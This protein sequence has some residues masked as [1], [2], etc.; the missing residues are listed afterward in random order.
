[1]RLK[2]KLV[3]WIVLG[4]A[5]LVL[6]F[7]IG[8]DGGGGGGSYFLGYTI[9]GK[10]ISA[11]DNA[12][13][14]N[15]EV[16]LSDASGTDT[17]LYSTITDS[18]GNYLFGGLNDG[19]YKVAVVSIPGGYSFNPI[20]KF[21][22]ISDANVSGINFVGHLPYESQTQTIG[23]TGGALSLQN[24]ASVTFDPNFLS[25]TSQITFSSYPSDL[26]NTQGETSLS[27]IYKINIPTENISSY[28]VQNNKQF[29]NKIQKQ[30]QEQE[31]YLKLILPETAIQNS[32]QEC[33]I[34][35]SVIICGTNGLRGQS[36]ISPQGDAEL[37]IP[38]SAIDP[39]RMSGESTGSTEIA[40]RI[41]G[42]ITG[43]IVKNASHIQSA[44]FSFENNMKINSYWDEKGNA[45][46]YTGNKKIIILIHGW[47]GLTAASY[48]LSEDE[49]NVYEGMGLIKVQDILKPQYFGWENFAKFFYHDTQLSETF[50]LFTYRYDTDEDVNISAENLYRAINA[51]FTNKEI[52]LIGHSMGGLVGHTLLCNHPDLY[53]YS[54]SGNKIKKLITL[55]TPFHGSPIVQTEI[56]Q[57]VS[58]VAEFMGWVGLSSDGFKELAWDGF[59]RNSSI[60]SPD[61]SPWVNKISREPVPIYSMYFPIAGKFTSNIFNSH[62][63]YD[64]INN[65]LNAYGYTNDGIVP[66]CSSLFRDYDPASSSYVSKPYIN[67]S[68]PFEDYDHSQIQTGKNS[69]DTT[70]FEKIKGIL[71]PTQSGFQVKIIDHSNSPVSGA[72]VILHNQDGTIKEYKTTGNDGTADFG[73]INQDRVTLTV[74]WIEHSDGTATNYDIQSFIDIP[75][76]KNQTNTIQVYTFNKIASINV[77]TAGSGFDYVTYGFLNCHS[78][79]LLITGSGYSIC[80]YSSPAGQ[81]AT[82]DVHSNEIQPDGKI[83]IAAVGFSP[84]G[85]FVKYGYL[86]DQTLVDSGTYTV[87]LDKT[88]VDIN[89]SS[90]KPLNWVS[91]GFGRKSVYNRISYYYLT[92][93]VNGSFKVANQF[94]PDIDYIFSEAGVWGTNYDTVLY[95]W[96]KYSS[97]PSSLSINMPD[98]SVDN[99]TFDGRYVNWVIGG[100]AQ[101]DAIEI[102]LRFTDGNSWTDWTIWVNP[103]STSWD[104]TK[105]QL[106]SGIQ[107]WLFNYHLAESIDVDVVNYDTINGFDDLARTYLANPD[108]YSLAN[109]MYMASRDLNFGV[110]NFGVSEI[111][112]ASKELSEKVFRKKPE[113]KKFLFRK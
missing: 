105:L 64:R 96:K 9:S 76:L 10:V 103:S 7:G 50:D 29:S 90:N 94:P 34:I 111:N 40:I 3:N 42:E 44:L 15:M 43:E 75:Y 104:I 100:T 37:I 68:V 60:P 46:P 49:Y 84:F 41:T 63:L 54:S 98:I 20:Q 52:V 80:G 13:L 71:L 33:R 51:V 24:G 17:T 53:N 81:T 2:N 18:S 26:M 65:I 35:D 74:A 87:N 11:S 78:T 1:M 32:T 73:T 107:G 108:L 56:A 72:Y 69:D 79:L 97:I 67:E 92:P 113:Y 102:G 8:C 58:H 88:P 85:E 57:I 23:I 47:Q 109:E 4:L 66:E 25:S 77:N 12:G 110:S 6:A 62:G 101:K 21:I 112:P 99:L 82:M 70:V 55:S 27:Y 39:L 95:Q 16:I 30:N 36:L 91:L 61:L 38:L 93:V 45:K 5:G 86:L 28:F 59:D 14:S 89:F 31:P 22:T 48:L 106:P 83:S 19:E